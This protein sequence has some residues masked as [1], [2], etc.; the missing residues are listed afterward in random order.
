VAVYGAGLLLGPKENSLLSANVGMP[1]HH[2]GSAPSA[3]KCKPKAHV[4]VM[5]Y[6]STTVNIF[7]ARSQTFYLTSGR[8][9]WK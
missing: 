2:P 5:T 3:S 4:H 9:F 1:H 7:A 8:A 6:A